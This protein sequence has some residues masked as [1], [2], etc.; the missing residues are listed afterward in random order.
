[1][2]TDFRRGYAWSMELARRLNGKLTLFTVVT[3][4]GAVEEKEEVYHELM[5][6]QGHYIGH[7][8]VLHRKVP[9]IRTKRVIAVTDLYSTRMDFINKLVEFLQ[10][11]TFGIVVLEPGLLSAKEQDKIIR[12]SNCMIL[13][14]EHI[15]QPVPEGDPEKYVTER[16]YEIFRQ[17]DHFKVSRELFGRLSN[18]RNLF[19]Y[20]RAFFVRRGG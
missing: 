14:P 10:L 2:H 20:L 12:A 3:H 17:S 6:A 9:R 4:D 19:N 8:Q 11:E 16:F 1:M 7:Y 15:A 5:E 13:L 18:D